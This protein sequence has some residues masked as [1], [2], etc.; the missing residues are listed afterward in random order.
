VTTPLEFGLLSFSSLLAMV[1][2]FAAAPVFVDMTKNAVHRRKQM[3]FR[4]CIVAGSVLLLFAIAGSAI[5]HFFGITVPAF[6]VVGGLLLAMNALRS[7]HGNEAEL[8][9]THAGDPSIVPIGMP[10]V[11]GGG[12]ISAVMVL[13]GQAQ[14][15][16]HQ[17]ALGA[18][19]LVTVLITFLVFRAA[20]AVVSR[21]GK[22]GQE[23]VSRLMALLTAVIGVQFII[24]GAT[25]VIAE[26]MKR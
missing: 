2:P 20:P 13:A 9:E 11:A 17:A 16:L 22:T 4:A 26:L 3:A 1:D 12:A 15:R 19:I 6:Q 8:S 18:A 7:L 14:G 25:A 10:L 23:V 5:F 21:L 24:N